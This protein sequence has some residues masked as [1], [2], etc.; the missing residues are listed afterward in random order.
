MAAKNLRQF[1]FKLGKLGLVLFIA[2]LSI[3]LFVGFLLG[4]QVGR[5][6]DTYPEMIARG[7]PVRILNSIGLTAPVVKPELTVGAAGTEQPDAAASGGKAGD[8]EAAAAVMMAPPASQDP[9]PEK[10]DSAVEPAAKP[11]ASSHDSSAVSAVVTP[12]VPRKPVPEATVP[13]AVKRS[14]SPEEPKKAQAPAEA[15]KEMA[16]PDKSGKYTIQVVSFR[17]KD[18]ADALSQKIKELGY[19]PKVAMTE[20]PGKGQWYR[21]T[22]NSF[23]TKPAADKASEELT[24]KIK[25]V[26][27]VVRGK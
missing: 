1:E 14:Q 18:K 9:A 3:L 20:V 2:G 26:S 8:K 24:K 23:T 21:V 11:S 17:E 4:V 10:K 22:V 12:V 7:I 5:N 16:P 25:G 27:C 15:K 13:G 6:I 19:T